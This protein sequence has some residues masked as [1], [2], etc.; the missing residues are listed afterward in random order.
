MPTRNPAVAGT[1]YPSQPDSLASLIHRCYLGPLGPGR[2]P[3]SPPGTADFV[4]LISPHA[5][6]EYSGGVAAHSYLHASSLPDPDLLVVVGPNHYGLGS[7]VSTYGSG[8][9]KTPLGTLRVDEN[10]VEALT[11]E[12]GVVVT[13]PDSHRMEHSIEVQLPFLQHLYGDSVPFLPV[14]L[15]FQDEENA[16][17][18]A[19]GL[20]AAVRGRRAIVVASS[21][22]THY[23]PAKSAREKDAALLDAAAKLD[24]H[25]FYSALERLQVT[26]CGFGAVATVML[27]AKARG[28]KRGEVLKYATSGDT[29][30]DN[31][32]VVGYAAMRFT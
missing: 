25:G 21:D 17:A 18:V 1:F 14:S 22:F 9:W 19:R 32:Q 2:L 10:A 26:A 28:M 4:A 27:L 15:I 23:E 12:A 30:G 8:G 5:G 20:A 31:L 11:G 13:D 7:G 24:V 16:S 29:T 6:Y 3:P